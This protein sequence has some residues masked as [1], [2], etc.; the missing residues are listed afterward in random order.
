MSV[1]SDRLRK[2]HSRHIK[3]RLIEAV[4][5]LAACVS[6]FTT[7]AIVYILIRESWLFFQNVP[8]SDFLFDTQWTPLFED[9]HYGIM[10]LLS[11]TI[12]SSMV[13]LLVAIPGQDPIPAW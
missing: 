5:F 9:D 12:T 13:A 3:E 6:V 11:G 2:D 1:P 7:T 8:L 10:V 4:L